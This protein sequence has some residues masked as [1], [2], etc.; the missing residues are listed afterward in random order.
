MQILEQIDTSL[1]Y[2][3]NVKLATV[4]LDH[5]M[6]WITT[7]QNWYLPGGVFWLWLMAKGGRNGR[8]LG[9]LVILAI[10]FADQISSGVL[11]PLT[12]RLRPCKSL[13]NFRLLVHCGSKYGFP[14]SHA[15]NAAAV[16]TLFILQFRRWTPVWLLLIGLIGISRVY[17]GV[18]YPFDVVCGWALGALVGWGL[19]RLYQISASRWTKL[20]PLEQG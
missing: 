9:V 15:S 6:V 14:S 18:H 13:E 12:E 2:L 11:K 17:V 19:I 16:G 1:F 20:P 7:K 10:L 3:I 5:L 4:F 8:V